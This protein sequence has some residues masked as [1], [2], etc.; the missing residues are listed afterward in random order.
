MY[1]SVLELS[2][3]RGYFTVEREVLSTPALSEWLVNLA[4]QRKQ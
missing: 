3:D 2:K 1:S 4:V